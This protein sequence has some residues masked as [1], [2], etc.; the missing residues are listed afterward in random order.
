MHILHHVSLIIILQIILNFLPLYAYVRAYHSTYY[1]LPLTQAKLIKTKQII[2]M[3]VLKKS[4]LY[5]SSN[6]S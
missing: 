4:I 5:V 3:A 2:L 1:M 6:S